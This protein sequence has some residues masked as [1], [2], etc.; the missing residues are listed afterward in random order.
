MNYCSNCGSSDIS[1]LI[2]DGDNRL[3]H[4]CGNCNTIHYQ[5][6]KI[7]AGCLPIWKG[8]VL[9]CKRAIEPRL[10]YWNVPSGYMENGE[11]VEDAARREVWEE[12][13][14]RVEILGLHSIYSIPHINQVYIH[15]LGELVQ[16]E[17]GVGEESS[18][19]R[20]FTEKE[21]PWNLHRW[22]LI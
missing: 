1:L 21:I 16:G 14:A 7:V 13:H 3:R 10:G 20:L 8:E 19:V 22:D 5:N 18:E 2:P 11:T 6:P 4:V 12:A 17:Y 15:F 9:L